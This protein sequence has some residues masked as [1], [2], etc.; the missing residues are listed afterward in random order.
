VNLDSFGWNQRINDLF[1]PFGDRGFVAGRVVADGREPIAVASE[2][3][4]CAAVVAGRLSDEGET[5]QPV[6]GDWVALD[7]TE[8][9]PVIRAVVPRAG[10][11]ARRRPGAAERVQV[12]A[13]N[14][15]VV[16]LVDALDRGPNR[17]RIERGVAVAYDGGA[18]P[19]VVLTKS[20]LCGD[21]V[22]AEGEARAAAPFA[23][24]LSVSSVDGVG[25]DALA[26]LL[27]A[28]ST[29]VFLG[30]SGAGKSTL[31]N[32]LLGESRLETGDVRGGDHKG[33]HTTTRRELVS[34]PSGACLIDTPGIRELGLWLDAEAIDAAYSDIE[35]LSEG[36]RYRDCRHE[37][38]PG[39]AVI[40]AADSGELDGHRLEGYL[41]LR[42]EAES[43]ELRRST[44]E[45]RA[46]ER[47]FSKIVRN[48]KKVKGK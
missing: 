4:L 39:C 33:R 17:R 30:P 32:S 24:V 16:V 1:S 47:R 29:A 45:V 46:S 26:G 9:T 19:V 7:M 10:A 44:H 23:D 5:D 2:R 38:E 37:S 22:A 43:N 48:M 21:I 35:A 34:L 28:G 36:C 42:R 6:I 15:D 40:A 25:I 20:D 12:L 11:L 41:K 14:V 8:D 3:G 31:V 18:T 13:A 27:A